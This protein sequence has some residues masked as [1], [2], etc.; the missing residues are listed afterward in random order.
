[1]KNILNE[2]ELAKLHDI[3]DA[4]EIALKT[5]TTKFNDIISTG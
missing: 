2:N 5:S 3:G 1:M 4:V